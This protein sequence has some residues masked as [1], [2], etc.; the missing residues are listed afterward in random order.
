LLPC[1][2]LAAGFLGRHADLHLGQRERQE[3]EILQQPAPG[4]Q[5]I[6]SRLGDALIVHTSCICIAEKEDR[7]EGVDEQ[8]IFYRV[9]LFL[10]AITRCL[11]RRVLG[12]DD[13]PCGPVMGKSR[14]VELA[15]ETGRA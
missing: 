1:Q 10:A 9:I 8:D 13:P 12:A 2:L 4:R 14:Y 15:L 6:R 11:F 7:Q 3:A 5:G